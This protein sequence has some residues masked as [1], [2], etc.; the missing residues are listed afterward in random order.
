MDCPKELA[1]ITRWVQPHFPQKF[2][3]AGFDEVSIVGRKFFSVCQESMNS[4]TSPE[5]IR[6]FFSC[7][8][9]DEF[10]IHT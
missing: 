4:V 8:W 6:S 3:G 9:R 10:L 2:N 5:E 1:R 7:R